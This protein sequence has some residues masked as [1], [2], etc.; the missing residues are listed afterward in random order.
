[1]ASIPRIFYRFGEL[2]RPMRWSFWL[3]VVTIAGL[4]LGLPHIDR[5][6]VITPKPIIVDLVAPSDLTAAP[7]KNVPKP[8]PKQEAKPDKP[9]PAPKSEPPPSFDKPIPKK[10]PLPEPPQ[11]K[12]KPKP[13][14]PE[15]V[16]EKPTEAKRLIEKLAEA[17]PEPV[18]EPKRDFSSVLKNLAGEEQTAPEQ[19]P[20]TP[21]VIEEDPDAPKGFA[22]TIAEK[23]SISEMD[24]L[25][26]QLAGCWSIPVGAVDAQDL[27]ID[28]YVEM[29]P[30]RTVRTVEIID[31]SRYNQDQFF[32]AAAES[33]KRAVLNPKC[34][35]LA[36]PPDK[37][38]QW[39]TM[40]IRFNPKEMFGG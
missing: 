7:N 10:P 34:S 13:A 5:R 14:K 35:P 31:K 33:A 19:T 16:P 1:M 21:R 9:K 15:A 3:H 32:R 2:E 30:N 23:L 24:L 25:Q 17:P 22:A 12:P 6:P 26:Q 8:Q 27:V 36:V 29:R 4:T 37:Y 28:I 20:E 18:A 38:D 39:K 11:E 40:T